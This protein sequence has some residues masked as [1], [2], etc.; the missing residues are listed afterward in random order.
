M[1]RDFACGLLGHAL[2]VV[3]SGGNEVSSADGLPSLTYVLQFR[4]NAGS[5]SGDEG[6]AP[7]GGGSD[8]P[9]A[10]SRPIH[11][12]AAFGSGLTV[13]TRITDG[14]MMATLTP[15][16][17]DDAV[18][19]TMVVLSPSGDKFRESGTITFR[20]ARPSQLS[21]DTVGQGTDLG[22][23]PGG[24]LR[25][26]VVNWRITGGTGQFEGASGTISSS[27]L[28]DPNG[29]ALVDNHLALVWLP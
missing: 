13:T 4:R 15:V 27:F 18:M 21:F 7:T 25:H 19:E 20:G 22:P 24:K 3:E 10:P 17:G 12:P 9:P 8:A 5:T 23:V 14:A 29:D 1:L 6:D 2:T 16:P 28:F 11:E 26:G